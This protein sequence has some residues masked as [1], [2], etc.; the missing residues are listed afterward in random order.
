MPRYCSWHKPHPRW[1]RGAPTAWDITIL[2]PGNAWPSTLDAAMASDTGELSVRQRLQLAPAK[3][4]LQHDCSTDDGRQ[5]SCLGKTG[6]TTRDQGR[7]LGAS[8]SPGGDNGAWVA[9]PQSW[10][11]CEA[12]APIYRAAAC[13]G[14]N[15][16]APQQCRVQAA[17]P[18]PRSST[19]AGAGPLTT[20][21]QRHSAPPSDRRL[22]PPKPAN[23]PACTIR[24]LCHAPNLASV[25]SGPA[26]A[27]LGPQPFHHALYKPRHNARVDQVRAAVSHPQHHLGST[28]PVSC[29]DVDGR[30]REPV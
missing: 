2:L 1:A 17:K 12:R 25:V 19:C 30:P 22:R 20:R 6:K 3:V 27:T 14:A 4:T 24:L 7:P 18:T 5:S 23:G 16:V 26:A 8:A 21:T 13:H 15:A 11:V 9:V 10:Q 28:R 29:S